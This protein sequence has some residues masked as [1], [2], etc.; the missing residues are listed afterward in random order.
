M[1]FAVSLSKIRSGKDS[2]WVIVDRLTK[3]AH[4]LSIKISSTL[5]TLAKLYVNEIVSSHGV[6]ISIILD[7]DPKFTS[8]F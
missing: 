1:D 2:I 4:F 5:D 7:R 8:H 6:P 3:S